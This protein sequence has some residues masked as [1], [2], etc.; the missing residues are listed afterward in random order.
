MKPITPWLESILQY[1]GHGL[2]SSHKTQACRGSLSGM[3]P[4]ETEGA[5][6]FLQDVATGLTKFE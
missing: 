1:T 5:C 2:Y 3:L 4:P 6:F